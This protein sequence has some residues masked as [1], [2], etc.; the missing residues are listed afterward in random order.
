MTIKILRH[1]AVLNALNE[2]RHDKTAQVGL[3]P[4]WSQT[5]YVGFVVTRLKWT[6]PSFNMQKSVS[7]ILAK[8]SKLFL[9]EYRPVQTFSR[10]HKFAG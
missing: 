9:T 3:D 1:A 5:H 4:C 10:W 2:L 7:S 8:I 6:C